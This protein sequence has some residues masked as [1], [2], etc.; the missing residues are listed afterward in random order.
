M[1]T[2]V[3]SALDKYFLMNPN[4]ERI[5][6]EYIIRIFKSNNIDYK[7]GYKKL[8][9]FLEKYLPIGYERTISNGGGNIIKLKMSNI[10]GG[11]IQMK[12]DD[13]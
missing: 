9:K 3:K 4:L 13:E 6:Y 1:K 10:G 7:T 5:S 12:V 11:N 2:K 8:G